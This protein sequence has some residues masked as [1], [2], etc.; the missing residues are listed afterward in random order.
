MKIVK[1][2][3]IVFAILLIFP[4]SFGILISIQE[5]CALCLEG[6]LAGS[7]QERALNIGL[8][9]TICLLVF[10]GAKAFRR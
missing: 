5:G 1:I 9:M 7:W 8:V 10:F 4:L 3:G 6:D 2:I